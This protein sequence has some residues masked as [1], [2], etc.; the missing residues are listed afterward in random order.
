VVVSG[1]HRAA[2]VVYV[3]LSGIKL[4]NLIPPPKLRPLKVKRILDNVKHPLKKAADVAEVPE[5]MV[6]AGNMGASQRIVY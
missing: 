6:T 1:V 2:V 5:L 3:L 4:Q